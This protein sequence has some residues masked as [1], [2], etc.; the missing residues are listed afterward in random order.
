LQRAVT[1][2]NVGTFEIKKDSS[3]LGSVKVA[4][5]LDPYLMRVT[6]IVVRNTVHSP[7]KGGV[8]ACEAVTLS[9]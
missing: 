8:N 5:S 6:T 1:D 4:L 2:I 3:R 7:T 9:Y